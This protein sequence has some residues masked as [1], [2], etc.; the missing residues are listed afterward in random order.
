MRSLS[1]V[2]I[3]G[4]LCLLFSLI[5][6]AGPQS[7]WEELTE[8]GKRGLGAGRYE[9]ATTNFQAALKLAEEFPDKDPR[10]IESYENLADVLRTTSEYQRAIPLR[11]QAWRLREST[12]GAEHPDTID[13]LGRFAGAYGIANDH[14]RAEPLFR[15]HHAL[16]AKIHGAESD[17]ALTSQEWLAATLL[18]AHKNDEAAELL[19][20]IV[21]IRKKTLQPWDEKIAR[22]Y[23]LLGLLYFQQQKYAEAE[24]VY[25]QSLEARD[26]GVPKQEESMLG[27]LIFLS[28]AYTAQGKLADA[29]ATYDRTIQTIERLRGANHASIAP[30]LQEQS[31]VLAKMGKTA[32]AN[33][34]LQRAKT[35]R[36]T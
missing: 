33:N 27:P 28:K 26:Q 1:G 35:I 6:C 16:Q 32:E 36:G 5:S 2:R 14:T 18:N 31:A 21:T 9:Q 20:G 23:D 19:Y 13:S 25:L 24:K 11:E 34:A 10:K 15:Q 29:S 8:T 7:S 4:T 12:L 30:L 17:L 22:A 3:L